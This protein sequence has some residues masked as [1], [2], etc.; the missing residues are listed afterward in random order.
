[1]LEV[2]ASI[3]MSG[4][5]ELEQRCGFTCDPMVGM[6]VARLDVVVLPLAGPCRTGAPL[7][8]SC[9]APC[10]HAQCSVQ[11]SVSVITHSRAH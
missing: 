10:A 2:P 4:K 5:R 1:M 3:G 8:G 11:G 9:P 6:C 7:R